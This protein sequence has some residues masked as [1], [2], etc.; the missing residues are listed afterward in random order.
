[1][2]RSGETCWRLEG[3]YCPEEALE[4]VEES[5]MPATARRIVKKKAK[6]KAKKSEE[7]IKI[8][9]DKSIEKVAEIIVKRFKIHRDVQMTIDWIK[10][11][12]DTFGR[13]VALAEAYRCYN[14]AD[15]EADRTKHLIEICALTPRVCRDTNNVSHSRL[16]F[17]AETLKRAGVV[18]DREGMIKMQLHGIA[19]NFPKAE[20][21]TKDG[22]LVVETDDCW[23]KGI[24]FGPFKINLWVDTGHL[25]IKALKPV[26]G[27]DGTRKV[28]S[29]VHPHIND[30]RGDGGDICLGGGDSHYKK[31]VIEKRFCDGL[32]V[33]RG[34]LN[35]YGGNPFHNIEAWKW[36]KTGG[37]GC[38]TCGGSDNIEEV[39][40]GCRRPVCKEHAFK[41]ARCGS[42][43][44]HDHAQKC[45]DCNNL[46]CGP[47]R[48]HAKTCGI[49]EG[50][51]AA[52]K[53]GKKPVWM[54]KA[55]AFKEMAQKRTT[56]N[57]KKKGVSDRV[58]LG[59]GFLE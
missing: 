41:C 29:W 38:V 13:V 27:R 7:N 11:A 44:C 49:C 47:C 35:E 48:R 54:E 12:T 46:L 55:E 52:S 51:S 30:G 32:M 20:F 33:V 8:V 2:S 42:V 6:K 31:A 59:G 23:A 40:R 39:C 19:K 50:E 17:A 56:E 57:G 53:A 24:C 58:R 15:D 21:H 26:F 14:E 9:D 45:R 43:V 3:G 34:V 37:E 10:D 18:T 16:S 4:L 22:K 36:A 5:D 28:E 25:R 1:M